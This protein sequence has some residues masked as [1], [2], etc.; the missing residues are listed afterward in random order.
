MWIL[1]GASESASC[2]MSVLT[3]TNSTSADTGVDHPVDRVQPSA[4]DADDPNDRE[5]GARLGVRC[6]MEARRGLGHRLNARQ[7]LD[8]SQVGPWSKFRRRLRRDRLEWRRVLD[9]LLEGLDWSGLRL[10][11]A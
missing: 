1:T 2:W 10:W 5:V 7:F 4:A 8:G 6:S 11:G 3:A 9:G